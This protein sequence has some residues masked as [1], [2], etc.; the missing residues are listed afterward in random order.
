[1]EPDRVDDAR[2][3]NAGLLFRRLRAAQQREG[4]LPGSVRK[5]RDQSRPSEPA[6]TSDRAAVRRR[7]KY[8]A[9]SE[10]E[11]YT[12]GQVLPPR[13]SLKLEHQS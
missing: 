13:L 10:H 4:V 1:M 3:F 7:S 5:R 12:R 8:D 11:Y 9:K 2:R 6:C